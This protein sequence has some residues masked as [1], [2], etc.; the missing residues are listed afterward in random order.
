MKSLFFTLVALAFS[1]ST[2][3][4]LQR[5][6]II[7]QDANVYEKPNFDSEILYNLELGDVFEISTKTQGP[8]YRI[9]LKKGIVGW[10]ADNDVEVVDKGVSTPKKRTI[11]R[12][13]DLDAEEGDRPSINESRIKKPI[14]EVRTMGPVLALV[15][16]TEE[17]M[18]ATRNELLTMY[19]FKW[20]GVNNLMTGPLATEAQVLL[21]FQSPSYYEKVTHNKAS[22]FMSLVDFSILSTILSSQD[23]LFQ[24]G[25]GPVVRYSSFNP[26]TNGETFNAVDFN[27]GA[28]FNV[29]YQFRASW[30]FLRLDARY[31]LEKKSY[32]ATGISA[33]FEY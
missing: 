1:Y 10:I 4:A 29:G 16:F 33:L 30:I 19:G 27:L 28:Q 12:D 7:T 21:G 15:N 14:D 24:Y 2:C 23:S 11:V 9:R 32:F 26:Q 25:L 13:Q 8:F 5:G 18:A 22:G 17:T 3:W 20:S 31:I 6:K